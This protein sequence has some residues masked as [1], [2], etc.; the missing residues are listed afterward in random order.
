MNAG[1]TISHGHVKGG[2]KALLEST[3]V[4]NTYSNTTKPRAL[5]SFSY[6]SYVPLEKTLEP[7]VSY[8]GEAPP[9]AVATNEEKPSHVPRSL[10]AILAHRKCLL[11]FNYPCVKKIKPL[12]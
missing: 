6:V 12:V 10:S 9:L 3:E 4:K 7:I 5:T 8:A 1:A 11:S 2:H